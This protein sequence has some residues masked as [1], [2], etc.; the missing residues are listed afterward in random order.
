MCVLIQVPEKA[1]VI[2]T[3]RSP[4]YQASRF[5]SVAIGT[6][7][8]AS[9]THLAAQEVLDTIDIIADEAVI[10]TGDVVH[11]EFS[12]S[13]VRVVREQLERD[14]VTLGEILSFETG[15]Q[16]REIG[17]IGSFSAISIRGGSN[18]QTGVFLDGISLNNG[19]NSVV[20][21]STLEVLNIES[22]DIY[23]GSSPIQLA[24]GAVAGSLNLNTISASEDPS[25]KVVLSAGSFSTQQFQLAH[26]SQQGRW[27]VVGAASRQ[28]SQNDFDFNNDNGTPLNPLDDREQQRANAALDKL[29]LL[30]RIGYRW[31]DL[32]RTD[33]LVQA[34]RR[35]LGVPEFRNRPDNQAQFDTEGY[36]FQLKHTL[37]G[38]GDWNTSLSLFQHVQDNRFSDL[39]TQIG[40]QPQDTKR[41]TLTK[42][43]Q[44]YIERIGVSGTF[45]LSAS[46]RTEAL[47]STDQIDPIENF[48]VDRASA[49]VNAQYAF[50]LANDALLI[51]PA[52]R[53]QSVSDD[54]RG[55]N[56]NVVSDISSQ[57]LSPQIGLKYTRNDQLQLHANAGVFHREP[58]FFELFG[59]RGLIRG[60]NTL[61]AE[62][63]FNLDA[64]IHYQWSRNAK[65]SLSVF[66]NWRDDLI[67]IVFN[68]QGIGRSINAGKATVMGIELAN[69]FRYKEKY[70]A[71]FNWTL[72]DTNSLS[73][74]LAFRNQQLPGQ[75]RS[76]AF[77][78]F[79]MKNKRSRLWFELE[80]KSKYF[81]DQGNTLPAQSFFTQNIGVDFL[82][83]RFQLRAA[84]SNLSD[85]AIEDFNGF[86]RPGRAFFLTLTYRL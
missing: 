74:I 79:Q 75:A 12:G 69:E 9:S 28:A 54:F 2:F 21:L 13:H 56:A 38:I 73:D 25:T 15:V 22:A 57:V 83:K 63:G 37:D 44:T 41:E 47:V 76:T 49:N 24:Q 19:G 77:A 40:L 60:T 62:R 26:R 66:S 81:F 31:S 42:G 48:E 29:G 78:R 18:Q 1:D 33:V 43:I 8:L 61:E 85:V 59:S 64:G 10:E 51:T 11:E 6:M 67:T 84:I 3:S 46:I 65:S 7:L 35:D 17:G 4:F 82:L 86:P 39:L 36:Q 16:L 72:Q 58:A 50:Y 53:W 23:R 32:S 45:G 27:D 71:Q 80:S 34:N 14:D 70:S 55:A 52:L 68:A 30:S 5:A 20:D